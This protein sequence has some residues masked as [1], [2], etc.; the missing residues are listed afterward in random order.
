MLRG[1]GWGVRVLPDEDGSWEAN[2]PALPE[3]LRRE[4]R[5]LAGNLQYRHLLR[6]PG[7]RPMGRWQLVQAILLFAG[8][9]FYLLFLLAAAAAAATDDRIA[10]PGGPGAGP[11]L[12]VA[13]RAVC[14]EA[15]GLRRGGALAGRSGH[16]TAAW[17][18]SPAGRSRSSASPCCWMPYRWWRRPVPML[19]LALG[20]HAGWTPQNRVDRGVGWREAARLLWPQTALGALVFAGFASAGWAADVVGAAARGR[21]SAGN[22][23]LRPDRRSALRTLDEPTTDRGDPGGDRSPP[24]PRALS[25]GAGDGASVA[26]SSRAGLRGDTLRFD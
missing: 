15:A 7:L 1:A 24:G 19:R 18:G 2:P 12:R 4:L 20:G 11:D 16:A 14:A 25:R 21:S 5:W 10:V 9:P 23:A 3:F 8:T 26:A 17:R 13:R 6:L 22:P